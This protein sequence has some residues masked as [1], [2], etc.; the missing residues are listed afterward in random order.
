MTTALDIARGVASPIGR[1]GGAFMSDP[2]T[3]ER[4]N[5][6]GYTDWRFYY[7]GRCG[8]LGDVD[9]DVVAASTFF[10]PPRIVRKGWEKARAVGDLCNAGLGYRDAC[11]EWGRKHLDGV[12]GLDRVV[13]L[14]ERVVQNASPVNAPLFAGWRAVGLPDDAPARAAQLLHVLREHR[15]AMHAVAVHASGLTPVE[16]TATSKLAAVSLRLFAWPE[17]WPEVTPELLAKRAAADTLTDELCAPAYEVLTSE[18][19]DEYVAL[20]SAAKESVFPKKK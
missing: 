5:E 4:G 20:L 1:I 16:A 12:D 9:A 10:I 2:A 19:G 6:L 8:V 18:E 11:W 14:T 13:E 17:P 3:L 7:G 15:G